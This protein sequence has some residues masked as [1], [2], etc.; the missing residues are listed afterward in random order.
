MGQNGFQQSG[1]QAAIGWMIAFNQGDRPR[2]NGA[3]AGR[4]AFHVLF[5]RETLRRGGH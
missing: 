5:E 3:V 4:D 2:E 1:G